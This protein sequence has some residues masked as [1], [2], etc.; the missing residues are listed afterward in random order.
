M[1]LCETKYWAGGRVGIND[2]EVSMIWSETVFSYL[3]LFATDLWSAGKTDV[4]S[5]SGLNVL[6]FSKLLS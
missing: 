4:V 6:I 5:C 2:V 3:D 1:C